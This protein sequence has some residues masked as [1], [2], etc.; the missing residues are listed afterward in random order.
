MKSGV[1]GPPEPFELS[2]SSLEVLAQSVGLDA[3]GATTAE[4]F[5]ELIPLLRD[6]AK[7]GL[8][9]FESANIEDRIQPKR[10]WAPVQSLIAV[11]LA[12]LTPEGHSVVHSHPQ[13]RELWGQVSVYAYGQDYHR[14]LQQR[15]EQLALAIQIRLGRP[16]QYRIAVD[17]SPLVD[18]RVAERAGIGWIGKNCML[19]TPSQGSFVF[20]GTLLTDVRVEPVTHTVPAP[21]GACTLCLDA[22]PTGALL[23]PGVMDATACLS[24]ITQCK[25]NIPRVYR[26]A[27]GRRIWGC[28]TCQWACPENRGVTSSSNLVFNPVGELAYPQLLEVLQWSNREFMRRLGN[29]AAAWRGLRTWQRNALIALGNTRNSQ[30][31]AH[32]I[33]YLGHDRDEFRTSSAWALG[34]IG[35]DLARQAV[36]GR[37]QVEPVAWV[38]ED[39]G[40]T[41]EEYFHSTTLADG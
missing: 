8:T 31:V 10:W 38:K 32:L 23:A 28:D 33:P 30:A 11:A 18:R 17:T 9:G 29:T 24:F 5:P 19:F 3:V 12:Y 26:A 22:C 4:S 6:Y 1:Q 7:R 35:G 15:M 2:L 41:I 20:L 16:V 27:M 36:C 34:R 39:I 14:V 13:R 25:G 21:C 37:W 40:W